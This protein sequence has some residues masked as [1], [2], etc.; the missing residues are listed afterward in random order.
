MLYLLVFMQQSVAAEAACL[1]AGYPTAHVT[2]NLVEYCT[3][4]ENEYEITVTL[5]EARARQD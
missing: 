2:W 1:R 5:E 4:E 3:R